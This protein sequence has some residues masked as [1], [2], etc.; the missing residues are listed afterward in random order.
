MASFAAKLA[1]ARANTRCK[2][3]QQ[4]VYPADPQI[5]LDGSLFH[6]SCA[7]CLDCKC[8]ITLSNFAKNE[9]S[10]VTTLL[11]KTHYFQRFS[12]NG[13]NYIGGEKYHTKGNRCAMITFQ[14]VKINESPVTDRRPN[15]LSSPSPRSTSTSVSSTPINGSFSFDRVRSPSIQSDHSAGKRAG[16]SEILQSTIDLFNKHSPASSPRQPAKT[17]IA[18]PSPTAA[19]AVAVATPDPVADFAAGPVASPVAGAVAVVDAGE[20]SE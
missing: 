9:T 5:N 19:V 13:G 12:T 14:G 11:C 20:S 10:N 7:K 6:K 15:F 18:T 4:S 2:I 3:C 8:Q 1:A 16:T 17:P